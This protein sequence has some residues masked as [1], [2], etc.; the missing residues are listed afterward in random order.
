MDIDLSA[1]TAAASGR[2][3]PAM[4]AYLDA[5]AAHGVFG[6]G[7]GPFVFGHVIGAVLVGL[8]L[9]GVVPNGAS[10]ALIV[11]QPLHVARS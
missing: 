8:A 1:A 2:D 10:V 11:S 7:I 5:Y 9:R 4:V 6:L 3:R